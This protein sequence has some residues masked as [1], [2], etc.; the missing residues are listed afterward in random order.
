MEARPGTYALLFEAT[1]AVRERVGRLGEVVLAPGC[2][3]YVGS[4]FG[5]GGVRA[6]VR[7]HAAVGHRPR[8]HMDYLRPHLTLDAVWYTHDPR[9]RE[10]LW[11]RVWHGFAGFRRAVP[12][13]GAS[14]RHGAS[15]LFA[16]GSP[17]GPEAFEAALRRRAPRHHPVLAWTPDA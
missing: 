7:H 15:H 6:R 3:V 5:P 8:W 14:D 10:D 9:R 11:A 4:A 17:P 16:G 2:Y 1:G 12:G 13:F